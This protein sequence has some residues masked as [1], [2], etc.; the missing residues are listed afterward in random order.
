MIILGLHG[1][2]CINL[3]NGLYTCTCPASYTGKENYI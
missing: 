2:T 1:G 3:G